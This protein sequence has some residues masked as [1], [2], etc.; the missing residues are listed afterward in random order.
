VSAAGILLFLAAAA[1]STA[2]SPHP[3]TSLGILKG[4]IIFPLLIGWLVFAAAAQPEKSRAIQRALLI[5][6]L[7]VA[8]L[9]LSQAFTFPRVRA[10]YDVPNSLALFLAPLAVLAWWR[11]RP[12][13]AVPL[14][15][16]LIATQSAAALA[17]VIGSLAL[18]A[19]TWP[20]AT[21]RLLAGLF[22]LAAAAGLYFAAT[23]RLAYLAGSEPNSISVR[24]QLWSISRDL[25]REHPIA[26]IG[27][28]TFEPAYQQKL[29]ERFLEY[30][31]SQREL[32]ITDYRLPITARAAPL[33][34]FVFR[35]PHNWLLSFWLNTG[36]AGLLSFAALNGSALWPALASKA[37]SRETQALAL[38][39]LSLFIF[40]L[41]DTIYWKNDL[42]AL[43]WLLLALLLHQVR[44]DRLQNN[45]GQERQRNAA[46]R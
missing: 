38:A 14:G 31:Q 32:L 10:I 43:H 35:D 45:I 40:G 18:G 39:L 27:L 7:I 44:R 15:A 37:T 1:V 9:G 28:G 23:G 46:E 8:F 3:L 20:K 13:A 41:V 29:H 34:E 17:A 36:L 42:A 26:G 19:V 2:V 4:W 22:L 5:S 25:V 24:R 6:A 30:E 16:A 11:G 33:P 21:S 12:A